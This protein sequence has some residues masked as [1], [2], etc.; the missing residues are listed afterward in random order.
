MKKFLMVLLLVGSVNGFLVGC[1]SNPGDA[2]P[3]TKEELQSDPAVNEKTPG[4]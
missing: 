4:T 1:N 2:A 3:P